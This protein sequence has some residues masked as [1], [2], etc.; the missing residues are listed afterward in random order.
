[1][2]LFAIQF[3]FNEMYLLE[4]VETWDCPDVSQKIK[5]SYERSQNI[6]NYS[7]KLLK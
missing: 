2:T 7:I 1:M 6:K 4:V 5:K 3:D